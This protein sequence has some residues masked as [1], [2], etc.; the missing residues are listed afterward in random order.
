MPL[1][2]AETAYDFIR[3]LAYDADQD[4]QRVWDAMELT[5]QDWRLFRAAFQTEVT[6]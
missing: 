1:P 6:A 3:Q 4:A 2:S 5:R